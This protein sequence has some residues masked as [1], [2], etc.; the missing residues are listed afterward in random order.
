MSITFRFCRLSLVG[1]PQ[2]RLY[3]R[4]AT[5][6]P[7]R[8]LISFFFYPPRLSL[9]FHLDNFL[10]ISSS[11]CLLRSCFDSN[12]LQMSFGAGRCCESSVTVDG[13]VGALH[14]F[15]FV[16]NLSCPDSSLFCYFQTKQC[17]IIWIQAS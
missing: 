17:L 11:P 9:S 3:L 15:K 5:S 13:L 2:M 1:S 7:R 8:C 10:S 6:E 16:E 4:C 12:N 14:A